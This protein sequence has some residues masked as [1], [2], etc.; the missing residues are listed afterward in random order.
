MLSARGEVGFM[1]SFGALECS[2]HKPETQWRKACG[3]HG[4]LSPVHRDLML[5]QTE[6]EV[7]RGGGKR[8]FR[9][10]FDRKL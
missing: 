5:L 10:T 1:L 3:F 9:E 7:A 4:N 6:D 8:S 2:Q